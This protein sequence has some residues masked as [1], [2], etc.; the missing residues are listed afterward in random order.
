MSFFM[1]Y[2]KDYLPEYETQQKFL[3][4]VDCIVFGFDL[5]QLKLL[6][7]KRKIEP[8]RGKWSLIGALI[9]EN[10]SLNE[11]AKK[12]LQATTGLSDIYLDELKTYSEVDRDPGERVISTTFF[13]LMRINELL[14]E[15]VE[16]YDAHWFN[17]DDI[18]EL[19][20]DHRK[21]V[22]DAIVNLRTKARYQPI[23]FELIPKKF[24]IPQIQLF[25]E[26]IYQKKLDDRNFR[27]KIMS[28]NILARTNEKDKSGSKKGAFLYKFNEIKYNELKDK[29]FN[30]EF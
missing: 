8:L 14:E 27:K 21:M 11:A 13:S 22:D 16:R 4:A 26:C 17:L 30:F 3:V 19:I 1:M 25:Y 24:T 12:V 15:S 29:G 10:I 5:K 28:L 23:G 9:K 7:F 6:L 20:L 2:K 18:P